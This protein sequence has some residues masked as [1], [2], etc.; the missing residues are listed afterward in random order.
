MKG[1]KEILE[2]G[3]APGFDQKRTDADYS[4]AVKVPKALRQ[5]EGGKTGAREISRH[6]GMP[7]D[8]IRRTWKMSA[9]IAGVFLC[10]R[11]QASDIASGI[12]FFD[13]QIVHAADLNNIANTAVIQP[14]FIAG[15][16][17]YSSS[18]DGL[19]LVFY[20]PVTA[21]LWRETY[22]N[23]LN[24]STTF[25]NTIGV[26]INNATNS[27]KAQTV[28]KYFT[29]ITPLPVGS[30]GTISPNL[31]GFTNTTQVFGA[32]LQCRT[33][34]IGYTNGD[35]IPIT[36]VFRDSAGDPALYLLTA[37]TGTITFTFATNGVLNL[38]AMW[39]T[40]VTANVPITNINAAHWNLRIDGLYFP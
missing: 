25:T 11:T 17:T 18:S 38:Y 1:I 2:S 10:L 8:F 20:D 26:M 21:Q 4:A 6:F 14:G 27:I 35:E 24:H 39:A 32:R 40:N 37:N 29:I 31:T 33:P 34:D 19:F 13:G 30:I 12:T 7:V 36:S 28:Q 23:L 5:L 15:K 22:A 9:L 16:P 3:I